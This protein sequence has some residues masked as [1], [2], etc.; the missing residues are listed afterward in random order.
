MAPRR[1]QGEGQQPS[2][3]VEVQARER[4]KVDPSTIILETQRSLPDSR[5]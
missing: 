2:E 4:I 1:E 3:A 5:R